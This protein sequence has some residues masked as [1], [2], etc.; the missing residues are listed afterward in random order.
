MN[1][2]LSC[3]KCDQGSLTIDDGVSCSNPSCQ[4]SASGTDAAAAYA[5]D[6]LGVNRIMIIQDGGQDPIQT[7]PSCGD[8]SLVI[9]IGDFDMEGICFTCGEQYSRIGYCD[10]CGEVMDGDSDFGTCNDCIRSA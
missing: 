4:Y 6:V 10:R 2:D 1:S 8:E 3:T 9:Q 7:C 5:E